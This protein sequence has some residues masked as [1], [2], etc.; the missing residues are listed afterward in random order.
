MIYKLYYINDKCIILNHIGF[1]KITK[2]NI[3]NN[4]NEIIFRNLL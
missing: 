3:I 4:S 1:K 2:L